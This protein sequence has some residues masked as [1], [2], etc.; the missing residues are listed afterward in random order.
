MSL[1]NNKFIWDGVI[2]LIGLTLTGGGATK[3]DKIFT[4]K[5][6]QRLTG[7]DKGRQGPTGSGVVYFYPILGAQQ[8]FATP[9]SG[10]NIQKVGLFNNFLTKKG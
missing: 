7:G 4:N 3:V 9:K 2:R 6:G 8:G 1:S 5:G 10:K